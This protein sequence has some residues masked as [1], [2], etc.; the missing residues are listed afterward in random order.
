LAAAP[1]HGSGKEELRTERLLKFKKQTIKNL[2]CY[3]VE[4]SLAK[5]ELFTE[6]RS[7]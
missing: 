5:E 2:S 6:S 4:S 3:F 1:W 7:L